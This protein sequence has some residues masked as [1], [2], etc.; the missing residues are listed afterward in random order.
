ML[1]GRDQERGL[2]DGLLSGALEGR[3]GTLVFLGEPGIGKSALLDHAARHADGMRL[4]RAAGVESETELPFAGLHEPVRPLLDRLKVI[5]ERQAEA[6]R[7]AL[8]LTPPAQ[9][10]RFA[11]HAGTLSLLAA[12]AEEEPVLCTV[13]DAH[14][15]DPGSAEAL[16]FT[17]R[18]LEAE[19][20]VVLFAAREGE[21]TSFD[22]PGLPTLHLAGLAREAAG[23][24]LLRAG[25]GLSSDVADQLVTLTRG[26]PLALLQ[27]PAVLSEAQLVGD[28]PLE[29]P[30][31]VGQAVE[32]AFL[33]RV[34]S[35]PTEVRAALVVAAA[36][37]AG[38]IEP[39]LAA[40][41]ELQVPAVAVERAE[42][43]GLVKIE[44]GQLA[45]PH[46]LVRSALYHSADPRER[47]AA[48]EALANSLSGDARMSS[49]A[50]HLAAA[51]IA[52]NEN[53]A[54]ELERAAVLAQNRGGHLEA[55]RAFERA[56]R[57]TPD[58][59]SRA[60]RYLAA[61]SEAW[62]SG[63]PGH[64]LRLLQEALS[65]TTDPGV[66]GDVQQ[67]RGRVITWSGRVQEGHALLLAEA[68]RLEA[69]D[70][71][72]SVQLM[73]E[74]V[75][76]CFMAGDIPRALAVS[77]RAF[78]LGEPLGGVPAI[79]AATVLG[80]ALLNH[81]EAP[82]ARPLMD[83]VEVALREA[84]PLENYI[85]PFLGYYLTWLEEFERARRITTLVIDTARERSALAILPFALGTLSD[86]E[87]RLG[88]LGPAYAT[89]V[90][91]ITLAAQTGQESTSSLSF[92]TAGRIEA[93][94]G[95]VDDCRAHLG[96]ALA[97]AASSG[98]GSIRTCAGSAL[99]LLE[100]GLGAA[101]AAIR[102][103]E[104]VSQLV[105]EQ[106]MNEPNGVQWAPDLIEAYTRLGRRR[107]AGE[108]LATL[109]AQAEATG[110]TWAVAAVARCR[111]L[112][113]D[114]EGFEREFEEALSWHRRTPTPFE[115]ARTELCYGERLRR[116]KRRADA[117][118]RLRSALET[119]EGLGAAPWAERARS[120]LRASGERARK[121][122]PSAAENLTAQELQVAL[123]VVGGATN[124]EAAARLFLSPKTIEFHLSNAYRK[125]GVRSRA[126]LTRLLS[127]ERAIQA[128]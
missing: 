86:L 91:S 94:L 34:R 103:L 35:L 24:L 3:S 40:L 1:V 7:T 124:R 42:A 85:T 50:W 116:A 10:D 48:H 4:L 52:P 38:D 87:L 120:E 58:P 11:V 90:E 96:R 121:R 79:M 80:W 122:D 117:R 95:R 45:F 92:V 17:C 127:T 41:E 59:E 81:G 54:V 14:W 56:A 77:R 125:L 104:P 29:D 119:F 28:E 19:G 110:S 97:L 12:A 123:V 67:L 83:R 25:Y 47:R 69:V 64:A 93:I 18:R 113:A 106:D 78:A 108:A 71:G 60:P 13:D 101:E 9:V 63:R 82:E 100:L 22:A 74:A 66:R 26:N 44:E 8:A 76:S 55:S 2:I 32:R 57:L 109:Q 43:A 27:L 111:G 33:R 62:T 16:V 112:R 31:P 88:R 21:P 75:L 65:S 102:A 114:D 20:I 126:Q 39:V 5:P 98:T 105:V 49:R 107:E 70:P 46:P 115:R 73:S 72:R 15:L 36:S 118:Q 84:D 51:T 128:L 23:E 37:G 89:A 6:V 99:G 68:E 61:G 53:V 30:L